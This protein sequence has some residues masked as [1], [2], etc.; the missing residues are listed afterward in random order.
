MSLVAHAPSAPMCPGSARSRSPGAHGR[1]VWLRGAEDFVAVIL[2][3]PWPRLRIGRHG[4]VKDATARRR[5]RRLSQRSSPLLAS[6]VQ[7]PAA[8]L[9]GSLLSSAIA[10]LTRPRLCWSCWRIRGPNPGLGPWYTGVGE[11]GVVRRHGSQTCFAGAGGGGAGPEL[12]S[13]PCG[14]R[15]RGLRPLPAGPLEHPGQQTLQGAP[16]PL[17]ECICL[18]VYSGGVESTTTAPQH[19]MGKEV[20]KLASRDELTSCDSLY[21]LPLRGALPW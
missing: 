20:E 13:V 8:P 16:H 17:A 11:K 10:P 19:A 14:L 5:L 21:D 9:C 7:P 1:S 3:P 15:G 6:L 12:R 2:E 18:Y 4:L